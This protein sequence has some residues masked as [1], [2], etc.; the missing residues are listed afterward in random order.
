MSAIYCN[1][2]E[3]AFTDRGVETVALQRLSFEVEE[4]ELI[5][6][7]GPPGC[8]KSAL[9]S[10][11][12]GIIQP[13]SGE[14]TLF[15]K[16]LFTMSDR[17]KSNFRLNSLGY[18]FQNLRLCESLTVAENISVPL[19]FSGGNKS[20]TETR[21]N[22]LL[23]Q[24]GLLAK[25]DLLPHHLSQGERQLTALARALVT[26]PK[27]LLLD[28]PTINLDHQTGVLVMTLLRQL[29]LDHQ[30][31]VVASIG[32]VRLHPFAHRIF[33]MKEGTIVSIAGETNFEGASPPF[34]QI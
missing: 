17:E 25:R 19:K 26:D 28:E 20:D 11:L 13:E 16:N 12:G 3:K 5:I 18:M 15:G 34:L 29:V 4:G 32:D 9:L 23:S 2:V 14:C 21:V 31:T 24:M 10:V 22:D 1:D 8:G 30:V 6:I 27:V 33:R 7:S